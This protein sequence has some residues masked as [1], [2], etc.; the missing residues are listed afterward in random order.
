VRANRLKIT[1][2]PIAMHPLV[3]ISQ[4]AFVDRKGEAYGNFRTRFVA[5]QT[6]SLLSGQANTN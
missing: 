4:R 1:N 6:V 2:I 3:E 5:F